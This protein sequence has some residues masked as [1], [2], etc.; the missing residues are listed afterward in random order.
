MCNNNDER[1]LIMW[2]WYNNDI[3]VILIIICIMIM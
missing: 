3:N 2:K 1:K